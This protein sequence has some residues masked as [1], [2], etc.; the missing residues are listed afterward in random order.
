MKTH[1]L[2]ILLLVTGSVYADIVTD[3]LR[4][5]LNLHIPD[6]YTDA[7]KVVRIQKA[8]MDIDGDGVDDQF[9]GHHMM[10]WGD[11]HGT[12]GTFYKPVENGFI[13]LLYDNE[14]IM[15]DRRFFGQRQT[16]FIGY[17]AEKQ[18][19]GILVLSNDS[20]I[21]NPTDPGLP[22]LPPK[23]YSYC[24]FF[25]I[26][27]DRLIV[28]NLDPVDFRTKD[29]KAFYERYFGK[30]VKSRA[31]Q[32]EEYTIEKLKEMGYEIPDWKHEPE[33]MHVQAQAATPASQTITPAPALQPL[34]I[35]G[36]ATSPSSPTATPEL[37]AI[38]RTFMWVVVVVVTLGILASVVHR[39]SR[40]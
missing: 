9:I 13:R 10:W 1:F 30:G 12:Y 40:K 15:I 11:N 3:P 4:D 24:Q 16:T 36:Q 35:Q 8:T 39:Q 14:Q 34:P 31:V 37:V 6:R 21:R 7:S 27:G 28:D 5:F 32:F 26:T 33:S 25:H 29:G 2:L 22:S 18:T 38:E 17:F 20:I 19:Q 23:Q